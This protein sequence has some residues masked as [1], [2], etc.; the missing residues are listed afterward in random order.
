MAF[1]PQCHFFVTPCPLPI[2]SAHDLGGQSEWAD[3][4]GSEGG[5]LV[6]AVAVG[7]LPTALGLVP[8]RL[9]LVPK[10]RG[11]V[12]FARLTDWR[13]IQPDGSGC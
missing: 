13:S 10:A 3:K 4:V 8:T 9:G 12:P 5:R 11:L 1:R 6:W 2:S 7:N